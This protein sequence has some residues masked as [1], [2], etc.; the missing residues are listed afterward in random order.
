MKIQ[1]DQYTFEV[2]ESIP[3]GYFIWNIPPMGEYIPLAEAR[4]DNQKYIKPETLK[5]IKVTEAEAEAMRNA[6]TYDVSTLK[7]CQKALR[8]KRKGPLSNTRRILAQKAI[9][10][11]ERYTA[12]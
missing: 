11:F 1:L 4:E 12:S 10:C 8:S 2:V 9:D 7:D 6:S 5:A 3:E